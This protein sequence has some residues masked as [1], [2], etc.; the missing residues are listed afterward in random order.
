MKI[1]QGFTKIASYRKHAGRWYHE[2]DTAHT[3]P[4]VNSAAFYRG[5]RPAALVEAYAPKDTTRL[6]IERQQA[7]QAGQV[8]AP[9]PPPPPSV[10]GLVCPACGCVLCRCTITPAGGLDAIVALQK[11]QGKMP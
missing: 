6:V 1:M 8:P 9:I 10:Q 5:A 3:G 7:R 11:A 2:Q 4:S